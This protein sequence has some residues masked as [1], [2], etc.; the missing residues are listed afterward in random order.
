ML[1]ESF[2]LWLV[3]RSIEGAIVPP[4][5]AN[6]SSNPCATEPRGWQ[7]LY[8]P[9]DGKCYKIFQ[10][11]APCPETMELSPTAKGPG[12]E[13]RCPP[14]TAQFAAE[15]K[16]WPIFTR[17]EC[18]AG[19]YFAPVE[20]NDSQ[21]WG[22]CKKPEK[23][24]RGKL[25]WP[26]DEKCY[27]KLTRG[28]CQRGQLLVDGMDGIAECGCNTE[29]EL[30]A[31]YHRGVEDGCYEHYTT[32]PC[33]EEGEIFLPG[34]QCGCPKSIPHYHEETRMCYSLGGIGPCKQGHH[35]VVTNANIT[36]DEI[37]ATCTCKP[38]HVLYSDGHCYRKYTRGPCEPG[39]MLMNSTACVQVPCKR[40]RL[41]FPRERT[42]YRIGTRGP[43]S[44]GQVV[45]YDHSVRP[46]VD[47]VSYNGVCGCTM[48]MK[49]SG[50]CRDL[51]LDL[52][53][54]ENTPGMFLVGSTCYKLYTQGPCGLG[55]WLVAKRRPREAVSWPESWVETG[56][57]A[58]K[59]A[60]ECR[61]GYSRVN[62]SVVDSDVETNLLS[63]NP[64]ECQP[65]AVGIANYLNRWYKIQ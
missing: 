33:L 21:R 3:I 57:R 29:G 62:S 59:V 32:G 61:P 58:S 41:Y 18:P 37:H 54:C 44:S 5:W 28:P 16:C 64:G 31:Y 12:A 30:A 50:K 20:S 36:S 25:F 22:V 35:Y 1:A 8:W 43:C 11:G 27:S 49:L 56:D 17:A 14:G 52:D 53:K 34:G 4:P 63:A 15:S 24:D 42:C 38:G 9:A 23:C 10:I 46:S 47:G 19:E 45:L 26:R 39:S 51:D 55:E 6:P 40:S 65:P 2:F 48:L 13:C 7:L 60:C